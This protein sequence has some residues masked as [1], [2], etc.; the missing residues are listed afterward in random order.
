MC[1]YV[2]MMQK[3]QIKVQIVQLDAKGGHCANGDANRFKW[4]TSQCK[5][6]CKWCKLVYMLVQMVQISACLGAYLPQ[7]DIRTD[8]R[9][10]QFHGA[11]I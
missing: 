8:R 4:C 1:E 11:A 3:V 9:R 5:W 2:Q 6:L 10:A 7:R